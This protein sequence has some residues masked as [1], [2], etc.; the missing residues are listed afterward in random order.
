MEYGGDFA[1][2]GIAYRLFHSGV[3]VE[4][5]LM[6][7]FSVN[8]RKPQNV[9]TT[10]CAVVLYPSPCI[11]IAVFSKDASDLKLRTFAFCLA[12]YCHL[13]TSIHSPCESAFA[14]CNNSIPC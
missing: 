12:I 4:F 11:L 9:R 5:F 14:L 6:F 13:R 7:Y 2:S 3:D 8:V 1:F 10:V